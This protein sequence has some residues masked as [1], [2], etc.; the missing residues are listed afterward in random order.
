MR[1]FVNYLPRRL[2]EYDKMVMDN[3]LFKARTQGVGQ[4]TLD[5]AIEWGLSGPML[6]ACGLEWD[7]RKKRPYSGYDQFEF[8]IPTAVAGDCYARAYIHVEEMRQ[9]LRIIQQCLDNMP[10]GPYKSDHPLTTPPIKEPYTMH[11]IETLI[12]HF[13]NVTY[14]PPMPVGEC[15]YPTEAKQGRLRLL[16][17]QRWQ[18][19]FLPH[20]H[21]DRLLPAHTVGA[22][23]H[24]GL[25]DRRPAR[26]AGERRLR[27]GRRR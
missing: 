4:Y 7:F 16:P 19:H 12:D 20:P 8:E 25:H 5:E 6:R 22:A 3:A 11:D 23:G 24:P 2:D 26:S 17:G 15:S 14:G 13:L 10:S 9:S 18:R 27:A 21:P 1:D